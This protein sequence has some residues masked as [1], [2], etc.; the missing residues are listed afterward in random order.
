[1]LASLHLHTA[2]LT[3]IA[4]NA[5]GSH[6]LTASHDSLVALWDTNVPTQDEVVL[7][8]VGQERKKR[9]K[10]DATSTADDRPVRKAPLVV[11]K[12][13]TGRVSRAVFVGIGGNEAVSAAFDSTLRSWDTEHGVCTRTIVSSYLDRPLSLHA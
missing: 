1:V 8:E 6:L 3:S 13:H 2:P 12:S 7:P 9:R 11:L 10:I 4:A 5:S